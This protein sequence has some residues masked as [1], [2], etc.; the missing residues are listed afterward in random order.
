MTMCNPLQCPVYSEGWCEYDFASDRLL[1]VDPDIC[2]ELKKEDSK[3]EHEQNFQPDQSE[4][5]KQKGR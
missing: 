5:K 1:P 2:P 3:I 4:R